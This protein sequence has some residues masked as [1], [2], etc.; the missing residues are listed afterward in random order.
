M[1]G[2]EASAPTRCCTLITVRFD[3]G[4]AFK[5][6]SIAHPDT[7]SKLGQLLQASESGLAH[8]LA[9]PHELRVGDRNESLGSEELR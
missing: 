8:D 2:S 9:V 4:D 1:P 5:G 3:R 6:L 7:R